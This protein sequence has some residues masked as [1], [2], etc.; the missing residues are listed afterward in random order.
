[1]TK[2]V[3]FAHVENSPRAETHTEAVAKR[4]EVKAQT[5]TY[6]SGSGPLNTNEEDFSIFPAFSEESLPV[7]FSSILHPPAES[8]TLTE[9]RTF[10]NF[11]TM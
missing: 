1:M 8:V 11:Y 9:R 3:I 2:S 7:D 4:T 6:S 5:C 10:Y